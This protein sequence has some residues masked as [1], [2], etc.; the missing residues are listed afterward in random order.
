MVA[1][2]AAFFRYQFP[3][4]FAHR[5][6]PHLALP[7]LG[8]PPP[9]GPFPSVPPLFY[10]C[11]ICERSSIVWKLCLSFEKLIYVMLWDLIDLISNQN[12]IEISGNWA[13][14]KIHNNHSTGN[15]TIAQL[16]NLLQIHIIIIILVV[17]YKLVLFNL[18]F[19]SA[20]SYY[21]HHALWTFIEE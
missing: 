19:I 10:W 9:P 12:Q 4:C 20:F 3:I 8:N 17:K 6:S 2:L 1:I 5:P 7:N 14:I 15:R 13:V 21:I 18:V 16:F 11:N